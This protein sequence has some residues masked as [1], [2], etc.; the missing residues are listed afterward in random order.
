MQ[1]HTTRS[2]GQA[3]K[4]DRI[5]IEGLTERDTDIAAVDGVKDRCFV[6]H[7]G[8]LALQSGP[9]SV[10]GV[11]ALSGGDGNDGGF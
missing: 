7:E 6:G 4:K 10:V 11:A 1:T 5:M 8:L 9:V 3:Q 2:E